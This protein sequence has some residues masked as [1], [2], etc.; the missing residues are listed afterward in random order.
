MVKNEMGNN[1][2][3]TTAFALEV[4]KYQAYFHLTKFGKKSTKRPS[5]MPMRHNS[6]AP[7]SLRSSGLQRSS[8]PAIHFNI[9]SPEEKAAIKIQA[10]FKG[11]FA[12]KLRRA[13][14]PGKILLFV[15]TA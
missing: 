1:F 6:A 7:S 12:K 3:P 2:Q 15:I 4:L 8:L 14:F 13:C 9:D 5:S 10:A 11:F